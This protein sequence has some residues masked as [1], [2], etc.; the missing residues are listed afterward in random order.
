ME[1][2]DGLSTFGGEVV[3]PWKKLERLRKAPEF[4]SIPSVGDRIV[5]VAETLQAWE[6]A[7]V[8][9]EAAVDPMYRRITFE[10][11]QAGIVSTINMNSCERCLSVG[12]TTAER[13]LQ[14]FVWISRADADKIQVYKT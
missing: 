1:L 3:V 6:E 14:R 13:C 2:V 7:Y 8:E 4:E 12:F 5:I 11:G 10:R 9:V